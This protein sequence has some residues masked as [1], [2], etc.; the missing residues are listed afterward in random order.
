MRMQQ[1]KNLLFLGALALFYPYP[2]LAIESPY[3]AKFQ[4]ENLQTIDGQQSREFRQRRDEHLRE[5]NFPPQESLS[6]TYTNKIQWQSIL[7][8]IQQRQQR[9]KQDRFDRVFRLPV[10]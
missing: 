6:Q 4:I 7:D 5:F 1:M 10:R 3:T 2:L 9:I 8:E